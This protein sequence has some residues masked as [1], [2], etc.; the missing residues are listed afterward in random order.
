M[1]PRW[2]SWDV[3][4]IKRCWNPSCPFP[5]ESPQQ[6]FVKLLCCCNSMKLNYWFVVKNVH[7]LLSINQ[8]LK[9][10]LGVRSQYLIFLVKRRTLFALVDKMYC[11]QMGK[12]SPMTQVALTWENFILSSQK[13]RYNKKS[14]MITPSRVLSSEYYAIFEIVNPTVISIGIRNSLWN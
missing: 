10:P 11:N 2:V 5:S 7:V 9:I 14:R 3:R 12:G 1:T 13:N 8:Q 6:T 4:K